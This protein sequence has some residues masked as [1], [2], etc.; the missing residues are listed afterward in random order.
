V[1]AVGGRRKIRKQLQLERRDVRHKVVR[2]ADGSAANHTAASFSLRG[3]GSYPKMLFAQN[4]NYKSIVYL[5]ILVIFKLNKAILSSSERD[6]V[7]V[8]SVRNV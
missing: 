8:F 5:F 2:L 4:K 3:K 6:V 1:A 7:I